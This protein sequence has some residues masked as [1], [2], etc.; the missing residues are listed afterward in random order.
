VSQRL[1]SEVRPLLH[2]I[3]LKISKPSGLHALPPL[4]SAASS[5]D[6][7]SMQVPCDIFFDIGHA[8]L[9]IGRSS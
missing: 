9:T 6:F 4:V 1:A 8:C 5:D 7:A 2:L 3:M